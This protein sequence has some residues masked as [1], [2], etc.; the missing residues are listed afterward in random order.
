MD[1]LLAYIPGTVVTSIYFFW[2]AVVLNLYG[3]SNCQVV[4]HL[5]FGVPYP[6]QIIMPLL[7]SFISLVAFCIV[8]CLVYAV[9]SQYSNGISN[10]VS[11]DYCCILMET[12]WPSMNLPN[13]EDLRG[14]RTVL[15]FSSCYTPSILISSLLL[16]ISLFWLPEEVCDTDE[17]DSAVVI[18]ALTNQLAALLCVI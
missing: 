17:S 14:C 18:L 1:E 13:N 4:A 12:G 3:D 6:L 7:Q 10:L 8:A 15:L 5:P 2:F 16:L 9:L 11:N